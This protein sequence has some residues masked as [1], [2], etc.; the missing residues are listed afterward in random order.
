MFYYDYYSLV[1]MLP[2]LI[3]SVIIQLNLKSTYGRYKKINNSHNLTGA[4]IARSILESANIYDVSV[5]CVPG[6][7]SD[8]YDPTKKAVRLS[9]DV[10]NGTSIASI[11]IAA[12]E[13][14]HAIQHDVEYIPVKIR[15]SVVGVTN[16]SSKL[17]YFLIIL[18]FA[19][20]IPM[21]CDIA[22]ICFLIIFFFQLI[23]LPVEFN[24]SARA[25]KNIKGMGFSSTDVGGVKKVLSSAALTYVAAMLV[26][27]GQMLAFILRFSKRN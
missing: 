22:V 16:F 8:H 20:H 12:H 2:L 6:N 17:L 10:Y 18:S 27:F 1:I 15:T 26:S 13:V 24:A 25:L 3:L 21:L 19:I 9:E 7:L 4:Q 5:E 11:G 14:G 23:T